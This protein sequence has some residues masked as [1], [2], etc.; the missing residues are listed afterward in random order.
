MSEPEP[1]SDQE[2]EAALADLSEDD[3]ELLRLW[4]WEQLEPR[5]IAVALSVTPNAVSLRLG[6]ARKRLESELRRKNHPRAGQEEA[7]GRKEP[8]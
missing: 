8:Q 4:A 1:A 6:R 5:E 7:Y 2:L 3:Q